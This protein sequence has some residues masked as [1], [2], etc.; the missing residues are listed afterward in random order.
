MDFFER[1]ERAHRNTKLLVAYFAAGVTALILALY[2]AA[3]LI[4]AGIGSRHS[5]YSRYYYDDQPQAGWWNPKLLAGVALGTLAVIAMGSIFKTLELAQGG[6]VVA[7]TLGGRLIS[8]GS[9]EP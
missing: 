6:S 4:F 8:P 3:L 1:Q 5:R 9:A 7:T 2:I